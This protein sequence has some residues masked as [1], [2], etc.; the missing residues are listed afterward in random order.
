MTLLPFVWGVQQTVPWVLCCILGIPG[1]PF[2]TLCKFVE[3]VELLQT[4]IW[5]K[6]K[7]PKYQY[8][9]KMWRC[10]KL[11][12]Q[13]IYPCC[14]WRYEPWLEQFQQLP[15]GMAAEGKPAMGQGSGIAA[16]H[17][18][19]SKN[20]HCCLKGK[21]AEKPLIQFP[22]FMLSDL[23]LPT[24]SCFAEVLETAAIPAAL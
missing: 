4:N 18:L 23:N 12:R 10:S 2:N 20:V 14:T 3:I 1:I 24:Y 11:S 21:L 22:P 16:G 13:Q 8:K 5:V 17:Q 19:P 7:S 6:P 15:L 9:S